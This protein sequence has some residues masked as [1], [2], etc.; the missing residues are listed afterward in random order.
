LNSK[1]GLYKAEPFWKQAKECPKLDNRALMTTVI[2]WFKKDFSQE[3]MAG[4]L[5]VR[6]PNYAEM[7]IYPELFY[8]YL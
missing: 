6:Y 2:G 3:H 8:G 5:N 4:R 7:Q 1:N